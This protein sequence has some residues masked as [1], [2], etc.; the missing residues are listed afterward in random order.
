MEF[1]LDQ[2]QTSLWP[3]TSDQVRATCIS[4]CADSSNLLKPGADRFEPNSNALSWSQ[5][6]SKL[7]AD[8]SQSC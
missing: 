6:G 1:G 2:L 4:T 5:T 3:A 7:V 8:L